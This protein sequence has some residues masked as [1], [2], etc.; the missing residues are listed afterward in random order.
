MDG[1]QWHHLVDRRFRGRG[2]ELEL[3]L[4]C[5]SVLAWYR[6]LIIDSLAWKTRN[7]V[8]DRSHCSLELL[9]D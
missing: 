8:I 5:Q 7:D 9:R 4:I 3:S 6:E 1:A 2:H